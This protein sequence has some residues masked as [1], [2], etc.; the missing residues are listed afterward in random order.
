METSL[1]CPPRIEADIIVDFVDIIVDPTHFKFQL[2][3][4]EIVF[5]GLAD[6]Y[7]DLIARLKSL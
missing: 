6:R 4:N 7:A 3:S 2:T 1:S 5:R